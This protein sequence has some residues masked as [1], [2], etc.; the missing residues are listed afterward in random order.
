MQVFGGNAARQEIGREWAQQ[1]LCVGMGMA[2]L[3]YLTWRAG[4]VNW[5]FWGIALP[6]FV[7]EVFN[8]VQALGF[9]YTV[10]PRRE[11]VLLDTELP[12]T[13][14]VYV[15][16]P[17]VDEGVSVL[18]PTVRGALS[19]RERYVKEYPNAAVSITICNDGLAAGR[20][21][22]R[23]T[24]LL[25]ARLGVGCITRREPGGAKAGNVEA[26]RRQL[27]MPPESL[28][29][30]F[31]ADM[32]ARSGFFLEA[33]RPFADPGVGWVQ[34]G[35]YYHNLGNPVA[36]WANEQQALFFEVLSG[37]KA[38]LNALFL[39]GTN[40]VVR[41][42]ALDEIGGFPQDSVTEDFAASILLHA[43]WKCVYLPG[44]LATG[45]GP[46]D[47]PGYFGQQNRWAVGTLGVL[48]R[49]WRMLLV[50]GRGGLTGPQRVQYGLSCTHYLSGVCNAV[51]LVAPLL[52]LLA[53]IPALRPVTLSEMLWHFVPYF[54][55][56]QMAFWVAS[57]GRAHA[58]GSIL[59]FGSA[60][61]LLG[62]F[63]TVMAGRRL[64]FMITPK[65]R[66]RG[67]SWRVL[68]PH[69]CAAAACVAGLRAAWGAW[70]ISPLATIC[71]AWLAWS[72]VLLA[73]ALW[74]GVLDWRWGRMETAD[75][76]QDGAVAGYNSA[77]HSDMRRGSAMG[78]TDRY[79]GA[80]TAGLNKVVQDF[81]L[82]NLQGEYLY[83]AK[84]RTKGLL[85]VVFYG[86]NS[87]PSTRALQTVQE[88]TATLPAGKWTALAVG[89]GGRDELTAYQ[90]NNG[91]AGLTFL[92]D[93]ELYQTR[94]WGVSHLPSVY[95]IAGKT[96]QVLAKMI[97]DEPGALTAARG[98][99]SGEIDKLVAADEAARQ[100]AEEKKAADAAAAQAAAAE[101]PAEPVKA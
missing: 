71:A 92:I 24:E 8:I 12:Q 67:G 99:L 59:G 16:I 86:I 66:R 53:G 52:Y 97:G 61:V 42:A 19:A 11:M 39:C 41:A 93:H 31:D 96:G 79:Y 72:L 58:R 64:A 73:A 76:S 47:L 63:L 55:L 81:G 43:R 38:R 80:S 50:P 84:A 17:T 91:L 69:L 54:A 65:R 46:M 4:V 57:G 25:A 28:I 29:V 15:L 56:S 62:S 98:V 36:R 75:A 60:P 100:A 34:T 37:G 3:Y 101:K 44:V 30:I 48:R 2:S 90:N 23:E 33:I 35:Q 22:W 40:L 20:A 83:T 27:K 89:E 87:A 9:Q 77:T 78:L 26:A 88:W 6:L 94:R 13:L 1:C 68:L 49:R 45:L 85:V 82:C 5:H 95:V 51:F 74:L 7:A 32:V 14:P 70:G 10:W 21:N 18:E